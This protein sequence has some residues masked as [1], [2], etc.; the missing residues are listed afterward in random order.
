MKPF[1]SFILDDYFEDLGDGWR[2]NTITESVFFKDQEIVTNKKSARKVLAAFLRC[3]KGFK[4]WF[5][6]KKNIIPMDI[7]S[8]RN[9]HTSASVKMMFLT[10]DRVLNHYGFKIQLENGVCGQQTKWSLISC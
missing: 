4:V 2:L 6:L 8:D 1:K 3:K 9:R 10:I 7:M 5:Y